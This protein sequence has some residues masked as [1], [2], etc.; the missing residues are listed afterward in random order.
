MDQNHQSRDSIPGSGDKEEKRNAFHPHNTILVWKELDSWATTALR[1]LYTRGQHA[2][3]GKT[4][5]LKDVF[6]S[7]TLHDLIT[8]MIS[9]KRTGVEW[10]ITRLDPSWQGLI[11]RSA[12]GKPILDVSAPSPL[13]SI[14]PS[15][16]APVSRQ[17]ACGTYANHWA[18][19][20]QVKRC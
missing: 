12:S 5:N 13:S 11:D 20:F 17:K 1:I 2:G 3:E 4:I 10:A 7:R 9:A 8:G 15:S 6:A 14:A 16:P 18:G 19:S